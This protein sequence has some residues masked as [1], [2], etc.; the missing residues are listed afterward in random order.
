VPDVVLHMYQEIVKL[1]T[2]PRGV[3]SASRSIRVPREIIHLDMNWD[4]TWAVIMIKE[5]RILVVHLTIVSKF[6][7]YLMFFW[8]TLACFACNISNLH[9]FN[10]HYV[11]SLS[12]FRDPNGQYRSILSYSCATNE[13]DSN[14]GGSCTRSQFFSNPDPAY[15]WAGGP[16]GAAAGSTL[17]ETNN[18]RRINERA[19]YISDF[20]IGTVVVS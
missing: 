4:T 19:Q 15:T 13:C 7:V 14:P 20:Y 16:M 17:G 10:F 2:H 9:L 18:A 6:M 12:G 8:M 11:Y 5:R 1:A 3:C